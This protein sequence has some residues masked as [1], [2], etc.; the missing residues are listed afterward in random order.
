MQLPG[1]HNSKS[2]CIK[3][4]STSW[5]PVCGPNVMLSDW[6]WE[7]DYLM[8]CSTIPYQTKCGILYVLTVQLPW[9]EILSKE[10]RFKYFSVIVFLCQLVFMITQKSS[11]PSRTLHPLP[12]GSGDGWRALLTPLTIVSCDKSIC[13]ICLQSMKIH[14]SLKL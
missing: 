4:C 5:Y 13:G 14:G 11:I 7:V 3:T 10:I 2:A 1:T 9:A 6:Y 12:L 8:W